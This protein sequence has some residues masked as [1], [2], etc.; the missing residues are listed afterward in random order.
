MAELSNMTLAELLSLQTEVGQEIQ[1]R[2]KI[3]EEN[4]LN[5]IRNKAIALGL[6]TNQIANL[7]FSKK[8]GNVKPRLPGVYQDPNNHENTWSGRGRKPLWVLAAMHQGKTLEDLL[9]K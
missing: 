9:I 7:L 3:E 1:N 4:F 8:A 5:E 2:R 6:D